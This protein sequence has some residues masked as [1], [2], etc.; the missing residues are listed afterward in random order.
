MTTSPGT[1]EV[2]DVA[3]SI[4]SIDSDEFPDEAWLEALRR[5]LDD[6][7]DIDGPEIRGRDLARHVDGLVAAIAA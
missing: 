5:Q 2:K 6:C 4:S 1:V 7:P 3:D